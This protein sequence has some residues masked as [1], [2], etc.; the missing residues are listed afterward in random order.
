MRR[1]Y[2]QKECLVKELDFG[3]IKEE[4]LALKLKG[5]SIISTR[6]ESM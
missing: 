2:W 4:W 1:N 6:G 5:S 3:V